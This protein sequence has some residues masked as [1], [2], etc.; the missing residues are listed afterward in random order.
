MLS[1]TLDR[2]SSPPRGRPARQDTY[3]LSTSRRSPEPHRRSPEPHD[4]RTV[5]D[6]Q[7]SQQHESSS[8]SRH[9]S[10][11]E[12]HSGPTSDRRRDFNP[13]EA[14]SRDQPSTE[15]VTQWLEGR[16][17]QLRQEAMRPVHRLQFDDRTSHRQRQEPH[18]R[19][20]PRRTSPRR[21]VMERHRTRQSS[22]HR[23]EQ[24]YSG[25]RHRSSGRSPRRQQSP[26]P[27]GAGHPRAQDP[28]Q[29]SAEGDPFNLVMEALIAYRNR[30]QRQ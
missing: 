30:A 18:Y 9:R 7:S 13:A 25:E 17:F 3:P 15:I 28:P 8:T 2:G 26:R 24:R 11:P 29:P 27:S 4:R 23:V 1:P 21:P 12:R 14:N 16:S 19:R 20:E 10:P 6:R 5:M 22:S